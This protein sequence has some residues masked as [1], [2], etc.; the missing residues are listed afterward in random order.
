[1]E[2]LSAD[3]LIEA[4]SVPGKR[5]IFG[6]QWHPED[7]FWMNAVSRKLFEEF[8]RALYKR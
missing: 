6:T 2:G 8:A 7:D 5:F 3:G 4:V 1:V